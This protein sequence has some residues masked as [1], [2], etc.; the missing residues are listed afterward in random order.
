MQRVRCAALALTTLVIVL[1]CGCKEDV[2]GR[3]SL[4]GVVTFKGEPVQS[5]SI[6][7]IPH[8]GVKTSG[9]AVITNGRYSIP[10]DK[11]LEPGAYTVK[12]SAMDAP[13]PTDEPGGLPGK[14]PVERLPEKYNNKSKLTAEVK[15]GETTLDFKL[16]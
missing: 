12:I 16:D 3:Q 4:S 15:K 10:A 5:G 7:F 2:G 9:G 8:P 1:A 13:A 11:G 6:E 14:D